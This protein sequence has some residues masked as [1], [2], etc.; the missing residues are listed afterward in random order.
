MPSFFDN[1]YFCN[2]CWMSSYRKF[3][4]C[5]ATCNGCKTRGSMCEVTGT[6]KCKSCLRFMNSQACYDRHKYSG[7][8]K[9]YRCCKKCGALLNNDK[10]CARCAR[11]RTCW[12]CR[13]LIKGDRKK[14]QFRCYHTRR[15][16]PATQIWKRFITYDFETRFADNIDATDGREWHKVNCAVA[17]LSCAQC[18][19]LDPLTRSCNECGKLN[20]VFTG[21]NALEDFMAWLIR[22][23]NTGS[24][25]FAHGGK[26]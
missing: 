16:P 18:R 2:L 10:A 5:T 23:E 13:Q 20:V 25:C 4:K 19:G 3:H 6:I 7:A 12:I 1:V 15:R 26:G 24:I 9:Q 21:S 17:M 14:H 8:C 22:P 11:N